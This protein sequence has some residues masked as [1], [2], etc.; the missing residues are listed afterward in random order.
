MRHHSTCSERLHVSGVDALSGDSSA[1]NIVTASITRGSSDRLAPGPCGSF[2]F[3]MIRSPTCPGTGT[4]VSEEKSVFA[5]SKSTCPSSHV[6]RSRKIDGRAVN[7]ARSGVYIDQIDDRLISRRTLRS[8][9]SGAGILP[10]HLDERRDESLSDPSLPIASPL[11]HNS[12]NV[13][14]KRGC[15]RISHWLW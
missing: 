1:G 11:P 14:C 15:C 9:P 2:E 4:P 12:L 7:G 6:S 13:W 3:Q 5:K 8:C 10:P